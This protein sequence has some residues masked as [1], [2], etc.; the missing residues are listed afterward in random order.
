VVVLVTLEEETV[1]IPLI[2]IMA[3]QEVA[4]ALAIM[5]ITEVEVIAHIEDLV[6][7]TEEM[8][9]LGQIIHQLVVIT[10]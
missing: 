10:A 4:V 1:G 5:I 3:I 2:Q 6:E 8:V 9:V 7:T